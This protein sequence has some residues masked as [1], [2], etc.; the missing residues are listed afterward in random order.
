MRNQPVFIHAVSLTL[1][2]PFSTWNGDRHHG[3][4]AAVVLVV[5]PREAEAAPVRRH[6]PH[7]QFIST[8]GMI[9]A[10]GRVG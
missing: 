10:D 7:V 2:V 6:F 4:G 1:P 9:T 3:T 5:K 8:K